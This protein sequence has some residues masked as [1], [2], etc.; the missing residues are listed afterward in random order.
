M[1]LFHTVSF[2]KL[3]N[4]LLLLGWQPRASLHTGIFDAFRGYGEAVLV[5][6][7]AEEV[8][9]AR[10]GDVVEGL[11]GCGD[12]FTN[13][14]P[15]ISCGMNRARTVRTYLLAAGV[16]SLGMM[17]S[18]AGDTCDAVP[19]FQSIPYPVRLR[20]SKVTVAF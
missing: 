5:H 19:S 11:S 13:F 10:S 6:L 8:C 4:C 15:D 20:F 7:A 18:V 12:Y 9:R 1:M 3:I 14:R 16:T 2:Y 17:R